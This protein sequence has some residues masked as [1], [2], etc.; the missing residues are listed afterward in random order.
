MIGNPGDGPEL[1]AMGVSAELEVDASGLGA[2][3]M[4]GLVVEDDGIFRGKR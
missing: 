3:E 1:S 2:V 4:V